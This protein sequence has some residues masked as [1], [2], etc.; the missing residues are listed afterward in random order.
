MLDYQE[1]HINQSVFYK[2]SLDIFKLTRS[3]AAYLT[4]DKTVLSM[5]ASRN[6]VDK[7][8]DRLVMNSLVLAPKIAETECL[9]NPVLKLSY[10]KSLQQI[11]DILYLDCISLERAKIQGKDFVKMLRKE[12]KLLQKMHKN[13]VKSLL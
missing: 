10:A 2:K 5:Y 1:Q 9:T 4:N 3:I 12:I 6:M 7:Y 13:Y 11:I 8:A